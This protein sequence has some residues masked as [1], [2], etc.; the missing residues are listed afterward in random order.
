MNTMWELGKGKDNV[1]LLLL[2]F[3]NDLKCYLFT[4]SSYLMERKKI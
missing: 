1:K 2:I 4:L 3:R